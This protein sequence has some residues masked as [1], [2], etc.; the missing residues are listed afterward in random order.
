MKPAFEMKAVAGIDAKEFARRRKQLMRIAGDDGAAV[1][2][3][4]RQ[5]AA[6][7]AAIRAGGAHRRRLR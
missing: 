1:A 7:H 4:L 6:T 3:R 2:V 5:H